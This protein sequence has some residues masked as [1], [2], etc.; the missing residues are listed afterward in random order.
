MS[1]NEYRSIRQQN[2]LH[3]MHIGPLWV[4]RQATVHSSLNAGKQAI[5]SLDTPLAM[6]I[7]HVKIASAVLQ[8]AAVAHVPPIAGPV[9]AM[10][11]PQSNS[12][13]ITDAD[14]ARMDWEVLQSTVAACTRCP[15]CK[16]RNRT[17][18]GVGDHRARWL[19]I[20]EGPGRNEDQ[21]GE[22]F[23]GP[24]GKLLDNML[25]AI[26]LKRGENNFIANV[27][28]CRPT[29]ANGRDRAPAPEEIAACRP[30]LE[31]QIALVQ[32]TLIIAFGKV[33]A[34]SLLGCDSKTALAALRGSV[35]RRNEIPLV[36]TYHPAYL[37][38]KPLDKSMSWQDLCMARR[39]ISEADAL[40][41]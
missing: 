8:P 41:G 13:D 26:D 38:R 23:V 19:L 34:H 2:L 31:R 22:P 33:A 21:Q 14:I 12:N 15:L 28:K 36:V 4:R 5:V 10:S 6:P 32:P 1:N 20:G 40:A 7:E 25:Q 17:V 35:H 16:S 24:A 37:L 30:Y 29:D 3:A 27:V 11:T 9:P 39:A 18:F